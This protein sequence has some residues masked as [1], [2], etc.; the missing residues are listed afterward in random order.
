MG[1]PVG[2]ESYVSLLFAYS[3]I[4]LSNPGIM[5]CLFWNF[6]CVTAAWIARVG[7]KRRGNLISVFLGSLCSFILLF[8]SW[9]I[10]L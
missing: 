2:F 10:H 9:T 3:L 7:G 1:N 5:L 8:L 4:Y 6:I